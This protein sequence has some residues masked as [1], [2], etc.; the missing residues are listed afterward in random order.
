MKKRTWPLLVLS[1]GLTL[2]PVLTGCSNQAPEIPKDAFQ[3]KPMPPEA[4]KGMR[5]AMQHAGKPA[6]GH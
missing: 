5:D 2:A 1:V 4:Q 6:P 3:S